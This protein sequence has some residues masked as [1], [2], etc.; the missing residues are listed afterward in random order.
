MMKGMDMKKIFALVGMIVLLASCAS[1]TVFDVEGRQLD[2]Q[3]VEEMTASV[4][5][6]RLQQRKF[7]IFADYMYPQRAPGVRL[8]HEEW[9]VEIG[10]DSIGF[11]LPYFGQVY[12]A[13]PAKGPGM[14]FVAPLDSYEQATAK[15]GSVRIKAECRYRL[16]NYQVYI[17]VWDNGNANI[18][19]VPAQR[20]AIRYT[21]RMDLQGV[22][23]S[24]PAAAIK[25]KS[26]H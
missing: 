11:F 9:G 5:R 24:S 8:N 13:D 21:G 16:D 14:I 4:V 1:Q 3:Q 17:D 10:R 20:D 19:V 2:K 6:E 7:R 18:S 15:D 12:V 26:K 25:W 23:F 22:F